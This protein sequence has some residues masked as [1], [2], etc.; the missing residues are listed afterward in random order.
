[1]LSKAKQPFAKCSPAT[2]SKIVQSKTR[3]I[4]AN[5]GNAKQPEAKY[6]TGQGRKGK[7]R[8]GKQSTAMQTQSKPTLCQC[9]TML[10]KAKRY[11]AMGIQRYHETRIKHCQTRPSNA[12]RS[13]VQPCQCNVKQCNATQSGA[14][15]I[16]RCKVM[17]NKVAKCKAGRCSAKQ[18]KTTLSNG[19]DANQ[20]ASSRMPGK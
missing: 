11:K 5:L 15:S 10:R 6:K 17:I 14:T 18:H 3:Q 2:Q 8:K 1:M 9:E 12:I 13:K 16:A 7:G 20:N 4:N 19:S